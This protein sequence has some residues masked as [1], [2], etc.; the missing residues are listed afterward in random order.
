MEHVVDLDGVDLRATTEPIAAVGL[1]GGLNVGIYGVIKLVVAALRFGEP[2]PGQLQARVDEVAGLLRIVENLLAN[3][4]KHTPP[5]TDILVRAAPADGGV[6]LA[7]ADSGP[8]V[9]AESRE[10]VFELFT[11]GNSTHAPGTGIGLSLVAQFAALHGGRAWV[12]DAPGGGADFRVWLPA[13]H[14]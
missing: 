12:E 6:E 7:V 9:P 14:P 13:R 4:M 5:G 3:S 2:E 1:R 10:A 8:G 11:R